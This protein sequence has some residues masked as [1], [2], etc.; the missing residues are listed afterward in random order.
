MIILS[1]LAGFKPIII[2]VTGTSPDGDE[3]PMMDQ[4]LGR[5]I[6]KMPNFLNFIV[7]NIALAQIESE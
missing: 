2:D 4:Y 7:R 5:L 3:H 1:R 6:V